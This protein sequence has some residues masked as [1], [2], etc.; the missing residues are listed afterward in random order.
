[1]DAAQQMEASAWRARQ[2]GAAARR[3]SPAH[4]GHTAS[5]PRRGRARRAGT[6][7][8]GTEAGRV[9]RPARRQAWHAS[10]AGLRRRHGARRRGAWAGFGWWARREAVARERREP[11]FKFYFQGIFK[12]QFSNTLSS[13]KMT[14]FENVPKIKDA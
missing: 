5:A 12:Y 10:W 13:K 11:F 7:R 6:A 9:S 3:A 8:R 1:M 4:G 2:A 14:S